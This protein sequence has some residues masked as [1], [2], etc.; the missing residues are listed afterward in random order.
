MSVE[1]AADTNKPK[2]SPFVQPITTTQFRDDFLQ[3]VGKY[4][5]QITI[6]NQDPTNNLTFRTVPSG[7]LQTVPPNSLGV[8]E[9]EIHAFL[10]V[11]PDAVT[12]N[13]IVTLALAEPA[14]L[15]RLGLLG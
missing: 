4:I 2:S 1:F 6:D 10:E 13:A 9:N 8:V 5:I 15:R 12:G 7:I 14:E 11:N 3:R